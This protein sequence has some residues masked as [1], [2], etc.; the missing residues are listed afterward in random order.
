MDTVKKA[1]KED[2]LKPFK[3][4]Q[5]GNVNG[6]PKGRRNFDTIYW[7]AMRKIGESQNM[8]PEEVE[9]ILVESGLNNALKG[10]YRFYQDAMD[11][12]HG[13]PKQSVGI[14]G[15]GENGAIEIH[16]KMV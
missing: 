10:D 7:E 15:T 8:T 14:D 13:K 11:R 12:R 3:K 9:D 16:I 6:R 1:V 2:N 4:G 5:S